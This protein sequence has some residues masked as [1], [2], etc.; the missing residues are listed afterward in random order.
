[1]VGSLLSPADCDESEMRTF[2]VTL[3]VGAANVTRGTT[4]V[5]VA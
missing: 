5:A 4:K 3:A 2:G 1:M